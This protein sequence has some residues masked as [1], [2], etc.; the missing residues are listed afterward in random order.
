MTS[1]NPTT[2]QSDITVNDLLRHFLAAAKYRAGKA[3]NGASIEFGDFA[4]GQ[5]MRS[6]CDLLRHMTE[7]IGRTA[8]A[9]S[10]GRFHQEAPGPLRTEQSRFEHALETLA[11]CLTEHQIPPDVTKRIL[12]GPLADVMTQVG[13]LATLWRLAGSPIPSENFYAAAIDATDL[14]S[15][16]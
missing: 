6:P 13:Q 4:T 1:D 5:G 11:G 10:D 14:G 15:A 7:V 16:I 12:Q 2:E 9:L 3:L 8:A